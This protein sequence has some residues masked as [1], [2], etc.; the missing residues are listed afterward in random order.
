MKL[1]L[2]EC[3]PVELR[4]ELGSHEAVT[5]TY[6]RWKGI[7]NGRLL[8]LAAAEGFDALITTDLGMEHSQ[9]RASLPVSVALLH[10]ESNSI[11]DLL[12]LVTPLL[13]VLSTLPPR[14]FAH[15]RRQ[16]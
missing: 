16:P 3:L 15:V 9:S 6:R 7:R 5:V 14:T 10:A 4:H 13:A 1:L 2:D 12:P 11:D 8:G